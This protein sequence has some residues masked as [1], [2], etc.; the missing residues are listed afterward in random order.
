M[1]CSGCR[2]IFRSRIGTLRNQIPASISSSSVRYYA[3]TVPATPNAA[4]Q[5]PSPSIGA[6]GTQP[7]P[8]DSQKPSTA[9]AK[10][11]LPKPR[12]LKSSVTAGQELKGLGYTKANPVIKAMEDHE[13]PDWLWT[14]L[15]DSNKPG[16]VKVDLACKWSRISPEDT[17]GRP[18][19]QYANLFTTAMTK[20]QRLRYDKA[21]ERLRKSIPVQIPLHEQSKDLTGE[22]DNAITSLQ[23]RQEVTKSA[24]VA[25]RKNIRETNF[26][27]SM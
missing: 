13:Y 9:S 5:Q 21:Q 11:D 18:G 26:L 4:S 17:C 7:N 6:P 8:T 22:G 12:K 1:I 20:K 19:T 16:E 15:D 3:S 14:L 23:R 10:P 27:K 25:N 2:Q 24:R